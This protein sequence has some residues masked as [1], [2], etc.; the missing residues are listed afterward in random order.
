MHVR[1]IRKLKK[2][3]IDAICSCKA[4]GIDEEITNGNRILGNLSVMELI[5]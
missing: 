2:A 3:N 5:S 1:D 4:V